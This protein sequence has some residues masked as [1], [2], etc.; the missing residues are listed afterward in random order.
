MSPAARERMLDGLRRHNPETLS[1]IARRSFTVTALKKT[2][3]VAAAVLL[4]ALALAPSWRAG[5]DANRVTYHVQATPGDSAASRMQ[6]AQYHGVDQQ[7]QPFTVTAE[8]AD[9]K[10]ADLLALTSP[11]GDI[12]MKSGAWLQLK[13]DTGLFHQKAQQLGLTGH[14]ILYR[15]DGST[16]NVAHADVDLHA[17][18]AT[19]SSP[20]QAQGPWGTLTA[21]NGF[22]LTNRG[23]DITFNGPATLTLTQVQ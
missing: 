23:T 14:V 16:M 20:V 19:S 17:G 3:P 7:G 12:T 9:Q 15:N 13:S 8:N 1:A 11:V 5:P 6:G 4:I 18:T 22:L 2:L 10:T 21:A